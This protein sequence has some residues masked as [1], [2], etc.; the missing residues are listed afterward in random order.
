[1]N[2]NFQLF[3]EEINSTGAVIRQ[4]IATDGLGH[5]C[6]AGSDVPGYEF[7]D[8]GSLED[9]VRFVRNRNEERGLTAAIW[10]VTMRSEGL[11]NPAWD[12]FESLS[13]AEEYEACM[14]GDP[15]EWYRYIEV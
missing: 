12:R 4:L 14:T 6:N 9:V 10:F 8:N 5:W 2:Y 13:R 1:M 7:L 3:V 11:D 15:V